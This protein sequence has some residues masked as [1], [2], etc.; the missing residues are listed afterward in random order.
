MQTFSLNGN[1]VIVSYMDK[2]DKLFKTYMCSTVIG[3]PCDDAK[4]RWRIGGR[5]NVPVSITL[6][7]DE[8]QAKEIKRLLIQKMIQ[9]VLASM[10]DNN[11]ETENKCRST[12]DYW[13]GSGPRGSAL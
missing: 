9:V 3:E 4:G 11:A 2:N 13:T 6:K 12:D 10:D 7:A 8:A 1:V 5:I